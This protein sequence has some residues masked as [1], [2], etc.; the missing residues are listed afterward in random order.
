MIWCCRHWTEAEE[1]PVAEVVR[2][3]GGENHGKAPPLLPYTFSTEQT[4]PASCCA[5]VWRFLVKRLLE[6]D[7]HIFTFLTSPP[8]RLSCCFN[9]CSFSAFHLQQHLWTWRTGPLALLVWKPKCFTSGG[10]SGCF[11][12]WLVVWLLARLLLLPAGQKHF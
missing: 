8:G 3:G 5:T 9:P 10:S 7:P 4:L 11:N 6:S 2:H 1:L 12:F